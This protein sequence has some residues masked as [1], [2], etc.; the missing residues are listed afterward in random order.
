MEDNL[1]K[2]IEIVGIVGSS[3]GDRSPPSSIAGEGLNGI[4]CVFSEEDLENE[5]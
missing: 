3:K 4:C 1:V 2:W 5:M